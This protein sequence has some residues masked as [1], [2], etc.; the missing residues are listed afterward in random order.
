M[1]H[2]LSSKTEL[3]KRSNLNKVYFNKICT[4]VLYM[5]IHTKISRLLECRREKYVFFQNN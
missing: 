4:F 5:H 3:R 2:S 1:Q